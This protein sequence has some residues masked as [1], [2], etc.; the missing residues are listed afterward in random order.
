MRPW[1]VDLLNGWSGTQVFTH[2]VPNYI[3]MLGVAA[4]LGTVVAARSARRAGLHADV[5][6]GAGLWSMP[7]ALVGARLL[8]VALA[9]EEYGGSVLAMF[10][11][12]RGDS[13]A[14]GGFMAGAA[15][16]IGYFAWRRVPLWPYL[17]CA[18]IG[19]GIGTAVTRLG[20][21][22]DGCDFGRLAE[23]PLAVS[24]PP[25][26][27]AHAAHA[28]LGILP[29]GAGASLPVHPVQLYLVAKGLL[30][31]GIAAAWMRLPRAAPGEAFAVFWMS[32]A[33][34]R[35]GIEFFRGDEGRGFIGPLSTSQAVSIPVF[36]AAAAALASRVRRRAGPPGPS[37]P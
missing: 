33:C 10:D 30:C 34:A 3:L 15:A 31:A 32:F 11:P 36:L 9:P 14:Y 4:V 1:L 5:I 13:L 37:V 16:T 18:A 20:C 7:A 29:A 2:L 27:P 23:F 19:A 12:I 24:F 17:D 28:A 35:F 22:L 25:G 21:F 26:S 6:Y 8:H